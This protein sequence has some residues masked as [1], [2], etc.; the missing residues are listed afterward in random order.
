[1]TSLSNLP[2]PPP[3]TDQFGQAKRPLRILQVVHRFFPEL[4]G[5]ET[6]VAEVSRRLAEHSDLDVTVL[7]TDRS[8]EL[9]PQESVQGVPLIRRRA[10][11]RDRDYYFSPGVYREIASGDWDVV[12]MQG[13]HTLVP[14]A[15]MTAARRSGTP[16][17]VTFHS[18]GH[19]SSTRTAARGVQFRA[20]TPLLRAAAQLV[21]V[22]RFERDRFSAAT[23]I[24]N[25][26]FT[27]I[28]NGG[29]LPT[30]DS[31]MSPVPGRIVSSGRLEQYKGHH[32]AIEALPLIQLSRPEARLVI[33][34][35][36]PYEQQ[37]H[38][39]AKR[40]GVSHAVEIRHLPPADRGAMARELAMAQVM[41]ALSSYEAHPVGVMEAVASGLPVVG[42]DVAGIGDLVEDG[43]VSGIPATSGPTEVAAALVA[44]LDSSDPAVPRVAPDVQLP[45]WEG[46]ADALAAVYRDVAKRAVMSAL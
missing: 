18:G 42:F 10:W 41:A 36:G 34:G 28:G 9:Q 8:G 29:S 24:A 16:Y 40:V 15:A 2:A 19:S 22:S 20:L 11:P 25:D 6:H 21:A 39:L 5:T 27:V 23:G 3:P 31:T 26:K 17:V 46:C 38:E 37:L 4:G 45:T 35:S 30:V 12:H 44:V 32:R 14:L 7:T 1:M 13:I 33:L 43:L